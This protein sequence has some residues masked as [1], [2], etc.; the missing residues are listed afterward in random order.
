MDRRKI[1]SIPGLLAAIII[2]LLINAAAGPTLKTVRLDLTEGKLHTLS[3][4]TLNILDNLED[5]LTLKLFW[6]REA[7]QDLPALKLFALRIREMLEEYQSRSEGKIVLIVIDPEPFSE[8]ED[9]AVSLGLKGIPVGAGSNTLYFGLAGKDLEGKD[10]VIPFIQP[11]REA[12]LENDI[13]QMIYTLSHPEKTTVGLLSAL[14]ITGGPSP[15]NPFQMMPPWMIS[16]QLH[17]QFNLKVLGEEESVPGDI[18]ILMVVHPHGLSD[19]ALYFADQFV[20]SGGRALVFA[21]PLSEFTARLNPDSGTGEENTADLLLAAWG[22]AMEPGKVVGDMEISRKVTFRGRFGLQNA[23]YLPWISLQDDLIDRKEVVT[24]Q[25]QQLNLASAG[26]L[27]Q[28]L[29]A[30]TDFIP[31]L[32]STSQSMLIP[33]E[34]V[35]FNPDPTQILSDFSPSGVSFTLGVRLSG[36]ASTAFPDGPPPTAEESVDGA[37]QAERPEHISDS[38]DDINVI[39]IA[40]TDLLQDGFWVDVKEF[41]GQRIPIPLSDNADLV[42]NA[43]DQLGGSAD[44]IGLRGRASSFRP[45]T[46]LDR[47]A[48]EAE[49]KFRTKEQELVTRLDE[50]EGRLRE[51]QARREDPDSP[52][53]TAEQE[54]EMEMFLD[55]KIKI[56]KDLREVQYQLRHDIER[57]Q[58]QIRFLNIGFAPMTIAFL[59][60]GTWFFRR[61]RG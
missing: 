13:S 5:T 31:L 16:D 53:M 23:N 61:R 22:V 26:S 41:F 6:S 38:A 52:E 47:V 18:D 55:E 30:R 2:F 9:E 10:L 11:D 42:V 12:F 59:A 44:L 46:L 60:L 25:L 49:F 21:D 27:L 54:K 45:F 33:A 3:E 37:D 28:S 1:F 51:L 4:G 57:L 43:L 36:P 50:T 34:K 32:S 20:L 24:A 14:P 48:R 29:E 58:G 39:V 8:E 17:R 19:K 40:D 7:A 35:A 56:R 15:G